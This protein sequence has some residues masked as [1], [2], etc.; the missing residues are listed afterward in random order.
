MNGS[1]DNDEHTPVD[2]VTN[3]DV[4]QTG[5]VIEVDDVI[6]DD[7]NEDDVDDSK[8]FQIPCLMFINK[9]LR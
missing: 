5:N 1:G 6:T 9:I 3:D 8:S 7:V 2:D 4:T